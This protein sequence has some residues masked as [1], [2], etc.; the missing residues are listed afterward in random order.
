[1]ARE[2]KTIDI[3]NIPE[4]LRIVEEVRATHEPRVLKRDNEEVA[5]LTPTHPTKKRIPR[6]KPFTKNDSLWNLIGIGHSGLGNI[7]ENKH[8]YLAEAYLDYRKRA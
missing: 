2:L 3:S 4:L 7:S 5:I 1:M 6:D 8:K